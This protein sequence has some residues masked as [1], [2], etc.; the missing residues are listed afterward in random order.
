MVTV[1]LCLNVLRLEEVGAFW[2]LREFRQS[3]DALNLGWWGGSCSQSLNLELV[4][5]LGGQ[6]EVQRD[7]VENVK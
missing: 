6:T 1:G 3:L 7:P 4:L 2:V 5:A